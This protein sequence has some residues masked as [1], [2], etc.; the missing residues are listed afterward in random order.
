ML[1][2]VAA[3]WLI[4]LALAPFTA[5]FQTC[6]LTTPAGAPT[7]AALAADTVPA[8]VPAISHFGRI[9][10]LQLSMLSASP[11]EHH[12]SIALHQITISPNHHIQGR[13]ELAAILRV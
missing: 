5:P 10:P 3:C 2:R 4:V 8:Y 6:D 12:S 9:R 13:I 7:T 11:A 1:S